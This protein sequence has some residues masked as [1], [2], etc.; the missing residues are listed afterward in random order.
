MKRKIVGVLSILVL[1]LVLVGGCGGGDGRGEPVLTLVPLTDSQATLILRPNG[2]GDYE[3]LSSRGGTGGDPDNWSCVDEASAD[4][5]TSYVYTYNEDLTKD[6]YSLTDSSG[7]TGT[8]SSV[9]IYFRIRKWLFRGTAYCQPFLS[10]GTSETEGTE[11]SHT[12][13]DWN[14]YSQTLARPGGGSWSWTDI[15][16]LQVCIGL[17]VSSYMF[18][19]ECTQV[20]VIVTYAA[21]QAPVA[22]PQ[23]LSVN[24]CSTLTVT[25]TGSDPDSN[26]LTYKITTLPG[27][28]DLYD[29]TGTGGTNITSIPYTVTDGTHRVTY[30]PSASYSGGDSFGFKV[31][32][33]MVDSTEAT[34]SI[35]V[36]DG[37]SIWYQ[38]SDNDGYGDP[39][40]SI[41]ACSAPDRYVSDNT[42]CDDSD[43]NEHPG[44]TWFKDADNDLYSDGT[45]NTTSCTR[46]TGYKVASELTGTSGDCDDSDANEHPGQTW[47]K[48][49]D[50]DLYSDGTTNTTSCTR[51]TGYK[52]ASELTGT[53][54][55]CDDGNGAVNPGATEV[56]NGVDD[57][58]NSLIDEEGAVGCSIYYKDA[59]GD[60]YGV[61]GDVKCL[62]GPAGQYTATRGGDSDDNDASVNLETTGVSD[63]DPTK[64]YILLTYSTKGGSVTSP[65]EGVFIY[66]KVTVVDLVATPDVGYRFVEWSPNLS[67]IANVNAAATNITMN[68]DYPVKAEFEELPPSLEEPTVTTQAATEISISSA[69]L[70][71]NYTM[72]NFSQVEVR[73]AYKKSND[74]EWSY[75]DWVSK[76]GDGT[77]AEVL[78]G[79]DSN[80]EYEFT[81]KLKGSATVEGTTL[82][83]TTGTSSVPPPY[84]SG[85]CFIATAAYG[86][87]TAEQIDVLR[88]FRDSVLLESTAGSQFVGLYYQLSPP[89]A[90]FIA[91][92]EILRTLVRELL[93]DPIVWTVGA[94]GEMW[95]N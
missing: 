66:N 50:N 80:T 84:G 13:T 83:F 43:A 60:T 38:D 63:S 32:D 6:A 76:S 29:G 17:K 54:G 88:E 95:R 79:L 65:G 53:S 33:G 74:T 11:Q 24:S 5:I 92:N 41:L 36:S 9:T 45:T 39:A 51:P 37:R 68:G 55:D 58:C 90:D 28:G 69:A 61:T 75:T 25:L 42:D 81:A 72:G 31:N 16:N 70:N 15:D 18:R 86:T 78:T 64:W 8:I 89:I 44:Q 22:N 2:A 12:G 4:D 73:F 46:P 48:D 77:H 20:Y 56:C 57:D 7:E 62:C 10:L 71:M 94:T 91:G 35:N 59:D 30:Q 93:V 40:I 26:P 82:Q 52:V 47:F 14:T 27:H 19:A 85:G 23:S 21:N 87:P 49:A 1:L 67:A 3:H 34:I